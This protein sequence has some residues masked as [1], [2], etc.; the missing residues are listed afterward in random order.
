MIPSSV[1]KGLANSKN[2]LE[3]LIVIHGPSFG[4]PESEDSASEEDDNS[5]EDDD[6]IDLNLLGPLCTFKKLR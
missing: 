2:T 4:W 1:R 6:N 5:H 3:E